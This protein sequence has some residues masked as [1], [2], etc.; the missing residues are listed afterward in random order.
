ML[1]S[2]ILSNTNLSETSIN[3]RCKITVS[4]K[5]YDDDNYFLLLKLINK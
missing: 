4:L 1:E 5:V 3:N 2:K